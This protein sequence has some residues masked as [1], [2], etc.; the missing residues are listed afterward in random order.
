[1]NDVSNDNPFASPTESGETTNMRP[2]SPF[3]RVAGIVAI[4]VGLIIET[5]LW[6]MV[7]IST[8]YIIYRLGL[9]FYY[10]YV[11]GHVVEVLPGYYTTIMLDPGILVVIFVLFALGLGW[12]RRL[13]R[14]RLGA[15][16][17]GI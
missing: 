4:Y 12:I 16:R 7:T 17:D 11:E 2:L 3:A 5:I 8:L 15:N 6:L 13:I 14:K 10:R 9:P 1:M